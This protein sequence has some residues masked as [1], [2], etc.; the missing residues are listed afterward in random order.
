VTSPRFS[1]AHVA[2]EMAPLAKVGGLADVVGSLSLEQARRGHRVTVVLPA[3]QSLQVPPGWTRRAFQ[4][5][6]VPWGM[7]KEPAHF[8]LAESPGGGLRVLLVSHEGE[9]GF[10]DRWGIYDDPRTG[11]GHPD[12]AER[13][14][15]FSRAALEGLKLLGDPIEILHAHDHQAAWTLCFLRTHERNEPAFASTAAIFTIHNLGYQ[16]IHDPWVLALAGF[17]R[18]AFHPASPFEFWGR[19]NDMKVGL[20][21]ADLLTTVS[22]TYAREIQTSDEFGFGLEGVL[23]TRS[24]DLVGLLNGID[25]AEWDPARDPLIPGHYDADR[26]AGKRVN[27]DVLVAEC[28]FPAA[29]D[30]PVVGMVSRLVEQKGFDLI[31]HAEADLLKLDARYVVLGTGQPGI[32]D[33]LR[34]AAH[35][36]PDRL[37]FRAGHDERFA[38]LIEAGADVYLMPSRYEPCGLNQM[39]SLRYG[40]APVVRA[41]G[42]LADTVEEFD[43]LTGKGTGFLFHRFEAAEMMSALRRALAFHRQPEMWSALQRNGMSR[44]FSWRRC[45]DGYDR[46]YARGRERVAGGQIRTLDRTRG[47]VEM[48]GPPAER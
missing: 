25:D 11:E 43:P 26:L 35:R 3:Y 24:A 20:S 5:C 32:Q 30:W 42:G 44:D 10:F 1:V 7:G 17:G 18:E 14:L 13:F 48:A 27:R 21:F 37:Y 29:P 34:R 6:E 45:A 19:V 4:G 22:P 12:N 40:T 15:F 2:S 47:T 16:G 39:Y 23:A 31:T 8:D 9:R 41:V 46:L 33:V 28:G 36:A 38:H